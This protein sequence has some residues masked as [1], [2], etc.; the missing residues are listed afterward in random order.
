[1]ALIPINKEEPTPNGK[2][3]PV[4][5][6]LSLLETTSVVSTSL[7]GRR[8]PSLEKNNPFNGCCRQGEEDHRLPF[9]TFSEFLFLFSLHSYI[10]SDLY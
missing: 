2:K 5:K 1:L 9:A 4:A 10:K 3:S 6:L 7:P 8:R